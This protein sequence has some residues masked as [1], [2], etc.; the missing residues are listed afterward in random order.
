MSHSLK[1]LRLKAKQEIYA[2]LSGNTLSRLYGEGYDFAEL[3]A[4][5]IG[6]DIRK[7]NWLMSAKL[8]RPFIKELHANKEL[9]VAVAALMDG[10]L[11]FGLGN[12]KQLK[13][14]EVVTTIGYATQANSDLF[15]GIAI[16]SKGTFTASPTKGVYSIDTFVNRLYEM[17]VLETKLSTK[18]I[19]KTLFTAIQKKSLLFIVGDFLELIDLSLL[20]QKHE[21]IAVIIRDEEEEDPTLS[22][23]YHF[24]SPK[25]STELNTYFGRKNRKRYLEKLT[26]H[27][28]ALQEHFSMHHI[29][30]IKI[31]TSDNI[32][33]RL[34]SLF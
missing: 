25:D 11:Y 26:Q 28:S 7:I 13:I 34:L 21:V 15:S 18:N 30:S 14:C 32:V 33:E 29:R 4:Y 1:I 8:G 16:S 9:S 3:R 12:D 22:H 5:Q 24:T 6:D 23:E 2:L 17:E 31:L 10:G 27:D 19:S 20:A